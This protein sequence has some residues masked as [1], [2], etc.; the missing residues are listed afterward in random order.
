MAEK[1]TA[2]IIGFIGALFFIAGAFL[3]AYKSS[4]GFGCNVVG[5]ALFA[6]QGGIV[7]LWSLIILSIALIMVNLIGIWRWQ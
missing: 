5:N 7:R 1:T 6:I 4:L 3:L 2:D